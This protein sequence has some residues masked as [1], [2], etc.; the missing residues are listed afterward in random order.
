MQIRKDENYR[1]SWYVKN[2]TKK[3]ITIGDL[4]VVPVIKPGR[5]VDLLQFYPREKISNSKVLVQLVKAR[6]V[7]LNKKKIFSDN[8]PG[9]IPISSIDKAITSAEEN[10]IDDTILNELGDFIGKSVVTEVG[11][12]G[13]DDNLV[14]EQGI[15]EAIDDIEPVDIEHNEL[16]GLQGGDPSN[17][18]FYH[19][20]S[21]Q[22][23]NINN[24]ID[25]VI[26]GEIITD[27]TG[28]VL[29]HG[30]DP[31]ETAQ[32][33]GIQGTENN[34]L[35]TSDIELEDLLDQV[36]KEMQIMNMH[37]A[38]ITDIYIRDSDI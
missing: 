27:D 14:T 34:E 8:L 19:I 31:D 29:L 25:E 23:E 3:N 33:V 38:L 2:L 20:N 30:K 26:E 36:I 10:E 37:M 35:K 4:P 18:E 9:P 24:I 21:E 5:R 32:P 11:D 17:D 15:R 7:S 28:G 13:S 1:E 16:E 6:I 22:L 12:P